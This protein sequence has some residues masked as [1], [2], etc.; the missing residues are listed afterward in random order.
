MSGREGGR[1]RPSRYLFILYSAFSNDLLTLQCCLQSWLLWAS[2]HSVTLSSTKYIFHNMRQNMGEHRSDHLP[3][4]YENDF[5]T[6]EILLKK[7]IFLCPFLQGIFFNSEFKTTVR[8][9]VTSKMIKDQKAVW[10]TLFQERRKMVLYFKIAFHD[11]I[12]QLVIA[13]LATLMVWNGLWI[14][15][16]IL[17]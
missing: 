10:D 11:L 14:I 5:I 12:A 16:R 6:K 7:L 8:L 9:F 2:F 15:K 13:F 1:S 3:C 17:K 4:Y